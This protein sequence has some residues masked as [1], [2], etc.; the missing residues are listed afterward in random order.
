M[1]TLKQM[2]PRLAIDYRANHVG[3]HAELFAQVANSTTLREQ[4]AYC[5]N[6]LLSQYRSEMRLASFGAYEPSFL[7]R[8]VHVI[9]DGAQEQMRW[10]AA[11]GVIAFMKHPFAI[12]NWAVLQ[13][14]RESVRLGCSPSSRD[15]KLSV[16]FVMPTCLPRPTLVGVEN[17]DFA[18]EAS[19]DIISN[20]GN[21]AIPTVST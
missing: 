10:V 15:S 4:F 5:V 3:S 9:A 6:V 7:K 11:W 14:P 17:T 2:L 8:I 21:D 12:R 13:F 19:C 1:P 18:P 16:S 20:H